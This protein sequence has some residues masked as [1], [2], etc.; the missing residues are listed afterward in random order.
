MFLHGIS[1]KRLQNVKSHL[2]SNGFSSRVHG[3]MRLA[4]HNRTT[5]ASLKH[6]VTFIENYADH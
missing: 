3:N 1:K 4:Q 6:V 2:Q 5:R